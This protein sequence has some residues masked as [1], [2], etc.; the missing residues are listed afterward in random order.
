MEIDSGI[1]NLASM[2]K[3]LLVERKETLACCESL[4]G[5]L[6]GAALCCVP[7]I[8]E[9]FRG[10]AITYCDEVKVA[11]GVREKTLADHT[12]ISGECAE[13]MAL[14]ARRFT[15]ADW[16]VSFTGNAGPTAQDGAPV[17]LVYIGVCHGAD[18]RAFRYQL[19]GDRTQ[20]RLAAVREGLRLLL[21]AIADE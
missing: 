14:S 8:S 1:I 17:G 5:G 18:V 21:K 19:E 16:A 4:T 20:V 10:G 9:C 2:A 11:V 7:G 13:E 3:A 15:G 12:A 6:F